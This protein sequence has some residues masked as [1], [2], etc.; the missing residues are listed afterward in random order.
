MGCIRWACEILQ[1][2]PPQ[3]NRKFWIRRFNNIKI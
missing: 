1:P 3:S 2:G